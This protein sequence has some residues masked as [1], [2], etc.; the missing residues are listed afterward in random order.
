M[1]T[2]HAVVYRHPGA[3]M[4]WW[5]WVL[6]IDAV[7][8]YLLYYGVFQGGWSTSRHPMFTPLSLAH[9]NNV[10]VWWAGVC[11]LIPGLLFLDTGLRKG[12]APADRIM[13]ISLAGVILALSFDEVG[14]L[15]ERVSFS[16][17]WWALLPF[18]LV[19]ISAFVFGIVR[20]LRRDATRMAGFMV[21][22]GLILFV[23][24]AGLEHLELT[25]F[26]A[27]ANARSRLVIE[28]AIE[29]GA[30]FILML[31]AVSQRRHETG[32]AFN[33]VSI[34][35]APRTVGFLD[36]LL[37]LALLGHVVAAVFFNPDVREGGRGNPEMWYPMAVFLLIAFHVVHRPARYRLRRTAVVAIVTLFVLLSIGQMHNFGAYFSLWF[38]GVIPPALYSDWFVIAAFTSVP[39]LLLA[40]VLVSWRRALLHA[41][42][43]AC[44]VLMLY[45]GIEFFESYYIFSAVA[46]FSGY[47]LLVGDSVA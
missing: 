37:F 22:I 34:L 12:M 46:A 21:L 33:R 13:W 9:E 41:A 8:V 38:P 47:R 7:A 6:A 24:I 20:M 10:A 23:V 11:L 40:A 16:G 43:L 14:S 18:A 35:V 39:M 28:E 26:F 36:V 15:H 44:A 19:G 2:P 42:G 1:S 27:G 17:G 45:P 3:A 31:A 4:P 29:L 5:L 25:S 30:A 32:Q